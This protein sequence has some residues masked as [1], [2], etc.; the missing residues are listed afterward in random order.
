M[1][2]QLPFIHTGV[3]YRAT[4]GRTPTWLAFYD[5]ESTQILQDPSYLALRTNRSEKEVRVL[6]RV[7]TIEREAGQLIST[8]GSYSDDSS[9]LVW[10][11]MSLQDMDD[12]EEL[13]SWYEEVSYICVS[14]LEESTLFFWNTQ[15]ISVPR[16]T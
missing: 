9:V 2:L 8:K 1:R 11:E 4:D 13:H 14:G 10:V 16:N 7:P 3:R 12:E 15:Q 5:L 6:D